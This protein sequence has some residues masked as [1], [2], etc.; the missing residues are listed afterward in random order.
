M[1]VSYLSHDGQL[2][3][4]F[5]EVV[6]SSASVSELNSEDGSKLNTPYASS[7][8]KIVTHAVGGKDI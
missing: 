7:L 4:P 3:V 8:A 6:I 1:T 5:S 2:S